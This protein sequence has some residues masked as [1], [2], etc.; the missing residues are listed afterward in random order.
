MICYPFANLAMGLLIFESFLFCKTL[1][2]NSNLTIDYF[3]LQISLSLSK[4]PTNEET[5]TSDDPSQ[6]KPPL[7]PK[8][9]M[10]EETSA[11]AIERKRIDDEIQQLEKQLQ[12]REIELTP[13][14]HQISVTFADLHD[15]PGR[16]LNKRVINDVIEWKTSRT[17]FYWRLRR[18][19]AQGNLVKEIM[20]KSLNITFEMA[21]QKL[22]SWHDEFKHK[23]NIKT[24]WTNNELMA[25]WLEAESND[26]SSY[27]N[28]KL[29]TLKHDHVLNQ[30][31]EIIEH[32]PEIALESIGYLVE[33]T[34]KEKI[35]EVIALLN[36]KVNDNSTSSSSGGGGS[37]P[38]TDVSSVTSIK[39]LNS[40]K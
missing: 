10:A 19:I 17:F 3:T 31:K 14:Y 5:T 36:E 23:S 15:T 6:N 4:K 39:K 26:S 12:K 2:Q 33:L 21:L 13:I 24:N 1:K 40:K 25:H 32:H 30:I 7:S 18:L 8:L 20:A 27:I 16:M 34:S 38:S 29:K 37:G 35:K 22:K 9:L 11:N 28:E